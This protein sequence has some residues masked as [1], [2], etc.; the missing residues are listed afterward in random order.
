[1]IN[2]K[3]C[4]N[5]SENSNTYTKEAQIGSPHVKMHT[6]IIEHTTTSTFINTSVKDLTDI[7]EKSRIIPKRIEFENEITYSKKVSEGIVEKVFKIETEKKL[8]HFLSQSSKY[9]QSHSSD[10]SI[11][12]SDKFKSDSS[13]SNL[14][15]SSC[16]EVASK[17]LTHYLIPFTKRND[18]KFKKRAISNIR[19]PYFNT[20]KSVN[21]K[22]YYYGRRPLNYGKSSY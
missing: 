18:E 5:L 13:S 11:I 3:I 15:F 21:F 14:S 8:E 10:L 2:K 9:K 6:K 22:P 16:K 1:M 12:D 19:K 20:N 7:S 4:L 17:K